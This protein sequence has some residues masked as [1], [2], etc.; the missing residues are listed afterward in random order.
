M[1]SIKTS[2]AEHNSQTRHLTKAELSY[3][4]MQEKMVR[5]LERTTSID[6]LIDENG[7]QLGCLIK[8]VAILF[9]K[10]LF[11][12][13]TRRQVENSINLYRHLSVFVHCIGNIVPSLKCQVSLTKFHKRSTRVGFKVLSN[14]I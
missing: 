9:T 7:L 8:V 14:K 1:E 5:M 10:L 6:I 11:L 3:K 2:A 4:K 13:S 12:F